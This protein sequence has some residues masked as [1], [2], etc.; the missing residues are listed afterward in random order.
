MS[1]F[2]PTDIELVEMSP[3]ALQKQ[4]EMGAIFEKREDFNI[5]P[6]HPIFTLWHLEKS[7]KKILFTTD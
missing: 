7:P 5:P 6:F 1:F 4:V 3:L 2:Y